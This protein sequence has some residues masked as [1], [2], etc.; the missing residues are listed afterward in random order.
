V[1]IPRQAQ[2]DDAI[3]IDDSD[4]E[5]SDVSEDARGRPRTAAAIEGIAPLKGNCGGV[6][7]I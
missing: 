2:M 1:R 7:F 4:D 3:A 5:N 6:L